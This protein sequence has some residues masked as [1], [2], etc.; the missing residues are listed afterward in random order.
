MSDVLMKSVSGIRGVVGGSFTPE[1]LASA[2]SAFAA[3]CRYGTIVVGRDSRPTGEALSMNLISILVL[4]GCNVIDL[5]IVPTPTVQIMVEELGAAGGIVMSASHNP[6]EWNALKLINSSGTFLNSRDITKYFKLMDKPATYRKWDGIGKI[7][8]ILNAS[9][10]HIDLVL[11]AVNVKKIQKKKFHVVLDSVN[12]A[13]SFITPAMLELL[14][15][16][17]TEINCTPDGLF[18]R[19][20]EPLPENLKQLSEAVKKN[21][22]DIGFA[23]DPD[24]DRLAIVDENGIPLGE[25]YTVTLVSDHLLSKEKGCVV[26]NLST[27][28]AVEDVALRHGVP[29]Y[30]AKVGEINVVDEMLKK[31]AR[32]GGEGNG[33]V[34]SPEIHHGRDSLAGIAY[35]LEMMAERNKKISELKAD[36]P[37]YFMKKGKVTLKDPS[38]AGEF[39]LRIRSDFS[40]EKI[41]AIDG[42]RIDFKCDGP[43]KNGWVHLRSSNTEPIFRIIAES[44]SHAKTEKIY[45]HFAGIFN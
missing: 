28:K 41:S 20:A 22:A 8:R 30:R 9:T 24:A 17:V 34:I 10:V 44:D 14:H 13:G 5:G 26:V 37:Q 18:P 4:N 1:L 16:R 40:N 29:F 23:Q 15:C 43:F 33:G 36:M 31:G 21:K 35:I 6:V 2:G 19:G 32:I 39:L 7:D 42:V 25:E 11:D 45:S 3:Y 27:T 38:S 12:G